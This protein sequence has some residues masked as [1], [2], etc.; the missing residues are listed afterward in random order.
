MIDGKFLMTLRELK[1]NKPKRRDNHVLMKTALITNYPPRQGRLAEYALNLVE[2][3][4]KCRGVSH[5]DIITERT[6][7]REEVCQINDK[8]TL[9]KVWKSDDPL[10]FLSIPKKIMALKPDIVH[11]NVHM[12]V[13]GQSRN[14]QLYRSL[15]TVCVPNDGF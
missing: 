9:H 7:D 12:A 11:F 6:S 2:E 5:I 3:L 1:E 8:V 4:Q 10:S 13:F 15:F 14:F